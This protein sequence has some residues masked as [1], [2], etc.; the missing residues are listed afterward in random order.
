MSRRHC[1]RINQCL[2]VFVEFGGSVDSGRLVSRL[3]MS[4]LAAGSAPNGKKHRERSASARG[5][6]VSGSSE[7][8]DG[9]MD[10]CVGRDGEESSGVAQGSSKFYLNCVQHY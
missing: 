1:E 8:R 7:D 10:G 4:A 2:T 6:V 9:W 3:K 5:A